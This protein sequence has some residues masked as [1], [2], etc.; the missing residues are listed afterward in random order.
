MARTM[1]AVV[2][3]AVL[4]SAAEDCPETGETGAAAPQPE[5]VRMPV[6]HRPNTT[7]R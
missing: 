7:L 2:R 5:D 6:F 4:A 3:E 1:L